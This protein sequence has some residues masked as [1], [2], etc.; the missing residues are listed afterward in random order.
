MA[1]KNEAAGCGI[2]ARLLAGESIQ[3]HGLSPVRACF[4]ERHPVRQGFEIGAVEVHLELIAR[5]MVETRLY[6]DL[7][8]FEL[9]SMMNTVLSLPEK[10]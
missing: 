9:T 4:A 2:L 10:T 5:L 3:F 8:M 1:L 7:V 6:M